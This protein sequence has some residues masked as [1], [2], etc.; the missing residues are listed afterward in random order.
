MGHNLQAIIAKQPINELKA[1]E[2]GLAVAY[3]NNYAIVIL[4]AD[5]VDY[6]QI[7]LSI[8]GTSLSENII[9][10]CE[11]TLFLAKELGMKKYTLIETDYFGGF[12]YQY[13]I[14]F[15]NGEKISDEISINS[16][17]KEIGVMKNGSLDEFDTI[18]LGEYRTTDEYYWNEHNFANGKANMIPGKLFDDI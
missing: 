10:A 18:N 8:N 12:G 16:A 6:W 14:V 2:Y 1:K 9:C 3:E 11:T 5:S 15:E 13:A 4:S 7:K 17:L